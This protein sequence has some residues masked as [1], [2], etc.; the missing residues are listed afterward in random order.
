MR[1][2]SR[3]ARAPTPNSAIPIQWHF[4]QRPPSGRG[5]TAAGP[6]VGRT[7]I[8]IPITT[9]T[10][11]NTFPFFMM[12]SSQSNLCFRVGPHLNSNGPQTPPKIFLVGR[13]VLQK[14]RGVVYQDRLVRCAVHAPAVLTPVRDMQFL[15]S[16]AQKEPYGSSGRTTQTATT[17]SSASASMQWDK[18]KNV[19]CR[20]RAK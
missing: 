5:H 14:D 20:R 7:A 3:A 19:F 17:G 2:P 12:V 1:T 18:Q 9:M 11:A 13:L 4:I 10:A 15:P 8:R 16:P 6:Q